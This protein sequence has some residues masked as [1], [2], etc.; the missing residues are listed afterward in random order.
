MPPIAQHVSE[1]IRTHAKGGRPALVAY[2]TAG[3]PTKGSLLPQVRALARHA[4]LIEVGVPFSDPMADG[5]TIQR[6]SQ[7]ALAN[8]VSL[9][10]VLAELETAKGHIGVPVALMSYLNPLISSFGTGPAGLKHLAGR[11]RGAGVSLLIVPDLPLEESAE[12]R[13]ALHGEGVGLVQLVS[14]V[15]PAERCAVL[16]RESDGFLY[17]VMVTG[18]TGSGSAPPSEGE[19]QAYLGRLRAVSPVPVCAGFGIRTRGQVDALAGHAEGA[20]IGS[21]IIDAI[22]QGRDPAALLVELA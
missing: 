3:Y 1:S 17:A 8:G 15:T 9:D 18:V 14:P 10:W 11:C 20:I 7:V 5:V 21:A 19:L 22:E 2:V 4:A 13:W 6:S 16:S 12:L